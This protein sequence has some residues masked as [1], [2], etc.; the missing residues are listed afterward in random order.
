MPKRPSIPYCKISTLAHATENPEKVAGA[1]KNLVPIP[2]TEIALTT[3]EMHGHHGN[4]ILRIEGNLSG[5]SVF[6]IL[7]SLLKRLPSPDE[8]AFQSEFPTYVDAEGTLHLR[9]DK[10]QALLGKV[11]PRMNDPISLKIRL[12]FQPKSLEELKKCLEEKTRT[13][14]GG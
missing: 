10:Q 13:G 4:R 9:F 11:I 6:M 3:T 7:D 8:H 14:D 12:G 1:I 2:V 5:N